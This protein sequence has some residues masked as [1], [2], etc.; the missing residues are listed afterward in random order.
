MA[1]LPSPSYRKS[2][3]T[4]SA[5]NAQPLEQS[6][7][8]SGTVSEGDVA[9]LTDSMRRRKQASQAVVQPAETKKKEWSSDD[10]D[11]NK[12]L[13]YEMCDVCK[14][15]KARIE[16]RDEACWQTVCFSFLFASMYFVIE[17]EFCFFSGWKSL[18]LS[19]M[20]Y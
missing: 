12:T 18:V 20:Q 2:V 7:N 5:S 9:P 15:K 10:A 16:C 19:R 13:T 3:T 1:P 4:A 6:Q 14:V 11:A 8:T 17:H